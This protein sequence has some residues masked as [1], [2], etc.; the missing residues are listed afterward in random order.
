MTS[1]DWNV[2]GTFL[3]TGSYDGFARLWTSK[4]VLVSTLGQ[5]KGPIFALK[6]SKSGNHI[7]TAGVDKSTIIWNAKNGTCKQQFAFH[8]APALDVDWRDNESFASCSTDHQIHV[9]KL[10]CTAP[11]IT[12]KGHSNEVNGIRWS[13]SGELL[14]SCS[15]DMT[16]KV[17]SYKQQTLVKSFEAHKKEIYTIKWSPTGLLMF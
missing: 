6:W 7:L 10:G 12:F 11:L 2:D 1:L 17:W 4:G 3:A 13:P 8:S 14:A 9:C 15:D 5:H 16:L